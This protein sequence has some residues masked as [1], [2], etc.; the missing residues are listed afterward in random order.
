MVEIE[1]QRRRRQASEIAC[2]NKAV[3]RA[4][5]TDSTPVVHVM[6]LFLLDKDALLANTAF[7][8]SLFRTR[9]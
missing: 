5:D 1:R 3:N 7:L 8:S 2:I 6:I 9:L 4:E